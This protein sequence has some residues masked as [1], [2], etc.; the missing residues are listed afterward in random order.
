MHHPSPIHSSIP[1]SIH[2][3]IYP[4]IHSSTYPFIMCISTHVRLYEW[5]M[6]RSSSPK[7]ASHVEEE[8]W[9]IQ[10]ES[11]T[12]RKQHKLTEQQVM[13]T[14]E[15]RLRLSW[16]R[17]PSQRESNQILPTWPWA[18]AVR[19]LLCIVVVHPKLARRQSIRSLVC[20]VWA[21]ITQSF[22]V[23]TLSQFCLDLDSQ[24]LL[25]WPVP[26]LQTPLNSLWKQGS[27][28]GR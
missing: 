19:G 24:P 23:A 4:H 10:Q 25:Y 28:D 8:W 21:P 14:R 26:D 20:R 12:S 3:S 18:P 27:G 16:E 11:K 7:E 2:S 15:V 1:P 22:L 5:H 13:E 9:N 17:W 6:G